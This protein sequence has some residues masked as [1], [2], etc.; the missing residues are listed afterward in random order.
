[1]IKIAKLGIR[2]DYDLRTKVE[3]VK[4]PDELPVVVNYT[5]LDVLA[6][7]PQAG[8]ARLET[9]MADPRQASA[10]PGWGKVPALFHCTTG[11]D[12]RGGRQPHSSPCLA[13]PR[14][15]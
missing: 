14:K 1:M 2:N 12:R 4:R 3:K 15:R 8:P 7:S 11:K 5:W 9:F 10:K 13:F 6:D